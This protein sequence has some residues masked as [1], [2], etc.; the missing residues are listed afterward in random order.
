MTLA[1]TYSVMQFFSLLFLGIKKLSYLLVKTWSV[2][3]KKAKKKKVK[4]IVEQ[5]NQLV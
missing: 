5:N 1:W 2:D 3:N 4:R